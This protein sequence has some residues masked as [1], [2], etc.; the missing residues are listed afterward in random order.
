MRVNSL[1]GTG[2]LIFLGGKASNDLTYMER[3]EEVLQPDNER[4]HPGVINGV[5][6]KLLLW[7]KEGLAKFEHIRAL[8]LPPTYLARRN[9]GNSYAKVP[10][11]NPLLIDA[12]R[13]FSYRGT[14]DP[15]PPKK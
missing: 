5:L 14:L 11:R 12:S 3:L 13:F 10:N 7:K 1:S 2:C 6:F 9:C 8:T 15:H 4:F